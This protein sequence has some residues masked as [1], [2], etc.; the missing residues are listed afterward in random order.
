MMTSKI[1]SMA[2]S[3]K[4]VS[5]VESKYFKKMEGMANGE[6]YF[7][8]SACCPFFNMKIYMLIKRGELIYMPSIIA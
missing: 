3:S 5:A 6:K 8:L 2:G 7:K 4:D 1:R